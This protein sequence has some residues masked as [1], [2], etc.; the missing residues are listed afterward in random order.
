MARLVKRLR[1]Q[2]YG[3]TIGGETKYICGCGLSNTQPFCDGTHKVTQAEKP[4]KIYWYDEEAQ[5]HE[6]AANYP[7]MRDDHQTKDA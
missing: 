3:V 6:V 1:S 7:G 5:P 2:P 4:G